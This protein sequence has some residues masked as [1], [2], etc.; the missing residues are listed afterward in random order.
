MARNKLIKGRCLP[1]EAGRH[2][3]SAIAIVECRFI[4]SAT[5]YLGIVVDVPRRN[6]TPKYR[7]AKNRFVVGMAQGGRLHLNLLQ[8]C[9]NAPHKLLGQ[10]LDLH[11]N[12]ANFLEDNVR[13][14]IRQDCDLK[15]G[16]GCV[17]FQQ[18]AAIGHRYKSW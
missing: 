3:A 17:P 1:G 12:G 16:S 18:N 6:T 5:A 4:G 2:W 14:T 9:L 11:W 7:L 8:E 15:V 10:A 13:A